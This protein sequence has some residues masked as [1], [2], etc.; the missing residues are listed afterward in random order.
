[1]KPGRAAK[2]N[3]ASRALAGR[4]DSGRPPRIAGWALVLAALVMPAI[5]ARAEGPA[6]GE[7][8]AARELGRQGLAALGKQDFAAADDLLS[9]AMAMH[10][11][12]TLRL[13]RA[14]TRRGLGHLL[15]AAEDYRVAHGWP[16]DKA[17]PPIFTKVRKEAA[18]E[19]AALEARIPRLTLEVSGGATV[20]VAG[21]VW[22]ETILGTPRLIDPGEYLI[23]A[24]WPSAET[25]QMRVRLEPGQHEVVRLQPEP[26]A[27]ATD[28]APPPTAYGPL[29]APLPEP[30]DSPPPAMDVG[31]TTAPP[32]ARASHSHLATW[33]VGGLSAGLLI[34]SL[35]TGARAVTLNSQYEAINVRE[36]TMRTKLKARDQVVTMRT[37]ST[38]LLGG[39]ILGAGV[40]T[41]LLLRPGGDAEAPSAAAWPSS[42]RFGVQVHVA[43]RF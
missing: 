42:R 30:A 2:V 43:G 36:T 14:R 11:A 41:L 32:P 3:I 16:L 18:D 26:A 5:P 35:A 20:R 33:I 27:A 25:A 37:V 29:P 7:L 38:V 9:R 40:T 23:E 6:Q 12:P 34:A 21:V 15:S 17:E 1:M 13:A 28:A 19:L 10:D 31:A 39:A 8:E 24:T 22:P 4:G